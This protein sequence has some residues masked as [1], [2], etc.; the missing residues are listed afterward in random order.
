MLPS[1]PQPPVPIALILC[2]DVIPDRR[3]RKFHLIG[4]ADSIRAAAFAHAARQFNVFI[5]L[6]GTQG[7]FSCHV[8]CFGPSGQKIFASPARTLAFSRPAQIVMAFFR[9]QGVRFPE[10]GVYR[11]RLL[12][13]NHVV[14]ERHIRVL[15][16]GANGDV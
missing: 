7:T 14:S 3:S 12:C 6:T 9:L 13:D 11:V 5:A 1:Q 10:P 4:W 15:P 2:D 8:D 16:K